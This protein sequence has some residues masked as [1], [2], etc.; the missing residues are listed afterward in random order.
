MSAVQQQQKKH[1]RY[2]KK[3]EIWPIQRKTQINRN[4]L[5]EKSKWQ[6]PQT[7][8]TV[9]KVDKEL[10]EDEEKENN[11]RKYQWRDTKPEKKPR[12]NSRTKKDSNWNEKF[13]TEFVTEKA[14][15]SRQKKNK[16]PETGQWRWSRLRSRKTR[17]KKS[18][19]SE[20]P[21]GPSSAHTPSQHARPRRTEKGAQK[22]EEITAETFQ[23]WKQTM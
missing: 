21:T 11:V 18:N 14:D 1:T 20:G 2:I 5:W 3:Q 13:I 10:K 23:M 19:Q 7:K 16:E 8:T 12:R 6:I 22:S 15:L 9:L 17:L 4:C